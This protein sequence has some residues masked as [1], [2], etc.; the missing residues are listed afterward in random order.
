MPNRDDLDPQERRKR[1]M[2]PALLR[3][4]V[5][6]IEVGK[7]AAAMR[8]GEKDFEQDWELAQAIAL[9]MAGMGQEE[10]EGVMVDVRGNECLAGLLEATMNR[11]IAFNQ[12]HSMKVW[13]IMSGRVDLEVMGE[14]A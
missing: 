8:Y 1:T 2:R 4:Q 13:A 11:I 3:E 6:A 7:L 14:S 10:I 5:Q 12:A 9:L